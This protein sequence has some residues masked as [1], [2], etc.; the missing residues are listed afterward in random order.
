MVSW[1]VTCKCKFQSTYI[2]V[3]TKNLSTPAQGFAWIVDLQIP[4]APEIERVTDCSQILKLR[5]HKRGNPLVFR[6]QVQ[7]M[8]IP[9]RSRPR[10]CSCTALRKQLSWQDHARSL[11]AVITKPRHQVLMECDPNTVRIDGL[12]AGYLHD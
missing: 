9:D 10:A 11:D 4:G 7:K 2:R 1:Q 12:S 6:K 5:S 3:I 8:D